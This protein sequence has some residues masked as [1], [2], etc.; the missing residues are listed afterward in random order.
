M[1]TVI[2]FLLMCLSPL[3]LSQDTQG[4]DPWVKQLTN[5][6]N[7]YTGC[8][9]YAV[10]SSTFWSVFRTVGGYF[11]GIPPYHKRWGDVAL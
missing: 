8:M 10:D 4:Y 5:L 11:A 1:K 3:A 7:R 2:G 6:P 9:M